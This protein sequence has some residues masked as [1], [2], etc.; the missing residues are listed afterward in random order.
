M[1]KS[2][3][4]QNLEFVRPEVGWEI[5]DDDL[6]IDGTAAAV[7]VDLGVCH[8]MSGRIFG[9]SHVA[10]HEILHAKGTPK[11][12]ALEALTNNFQGIS[13][14]RVSGMLLLLEEL[15]V[16]RLVK[17]RGYSLPPDRF[18]NDKKIKKLLFASIA[19]IWSLKIPVQYLLRGRARRL[20]NVVLSYKEL[21][22]SPHEVAKWMAD[23]LPKAL[24]ALQPTFWE[25]L[26][27]R[28]TNFFF[29]I[30]NFF[31]RL[32]YW[33]KRLQFKLINFLNRFRKDKRDQDG[34]GAK[35]KKQRRFR[36][37]ANPYDP[38]L[39]A[40]SKSEFLEED[41]KDAIKK[42][43]EGRANNPFLPKIT[44]LLSSRDNPYAKQALFLP[45]AHSPCPSDTDS[46]KI[47]AYI[48]NALQVGLKNKER[49]Y[50]RSGRRLVVSRLLSHSPPFAK[51]FF[52]TQ[53]ILILLDFSNSMSKWLIPMLETVAKLATNTDFDVI[54]Y[55]AD[56]KRFILHL[57][58]SDKYF[59]HAVHY[60]N[61]NADCAA[62]YLARNLQMDYDKVIIIGDMGFSG[63]S[64][65][66]DSELFARS[67][68]E[69]EKLFKTKRS[70]VF[71]PY[72]NNTLSGNEKI[73]QILGNQLVIFKNK[74]EL[75]EMLESAIRTT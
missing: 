28:A 15:R 40:A 59:S 42:K 75:K 57:I 45:P 11:K 35:E 39:E 10:I 14:E 38:L 72:D 71:A 73:L 69:L 17:E 24:E 51:H 56:I 32:I 16:E 9:D 44:Q 63:P 37:L 12:D 20:A 7:N 33:L 66:M 55:S 62:F 13:P 36:P 18:D 50:A 22:T 74:K 31:L 29:K 21:P 65:F 26:L 6:G 25:K 8:V 41:L 58:Y 68:D 70:V 53:K 46:M 67:L 60:R 49:R 64:P 3:L 34:A 43:R 5:M 1:D 23:A 47:P 30:L 52:R 27:L 54:A 61:G 48:T 2:A 4:Q 19:E